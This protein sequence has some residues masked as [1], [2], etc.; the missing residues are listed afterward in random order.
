MRLGIRSLP[1]ATAQNYSNLNNLAVLHYSGASSGNPTS[2]P[3]V[4]IPVSQTPLVET[5]LHVS[6]SYEPLHTRLTFRCA[7]PLVSST[8]VRIIQGS[9][10]HNLTRK[11]CDSARQS[12]ARRCRHQHQLERFAR[13]YRSP[14]LIYLPSCGK[15]EYQR[16]GFRR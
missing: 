11:P 13:R 2:D 4:N 15:L 10:L 16:H 7:Q 1:N 6:L 14:I 5:N 3:T 8:V 12:H 9:S